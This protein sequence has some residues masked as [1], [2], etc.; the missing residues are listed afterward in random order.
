MK[1]SRQRIRGIYLERG[2][3]IPVSYT[4]RRYSVTNVKIENCWKFWTI[5]DIKRAMEHGI[6]VTRCD[7]V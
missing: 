2:N 3:T 1:R 5:I 6:L 7:I 4:S